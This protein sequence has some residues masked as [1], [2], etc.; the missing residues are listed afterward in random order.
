[1]NR[2]RAFFLEEAAKCL[3]VLRSATQAGDRD[4][5][6]MH[7]AARQL[8]GSAQMARFGPVAAAAGRLERRLKGLVAAHGRWTDAV[9]AAVARE[10]AVVE[11]VVGAVEQ[12]RIRPDERMEQRMDRNQGAAS[13]EVAIEDL[14]YR[15]SA[16][17]DRA[18]ALRDALEDAIVGAEPVG[19][20]LDEL[21]DL[22][23][24]GMSERE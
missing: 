24:L 5:G 14:E 21:F 11:A 19:P 8:R 23:R 1:M 9:R 4:V 15:G 13:A 17:L 2:V 12:G 16:A 3:T 18:M 20:I 7:A 10:V 22:I 6:R